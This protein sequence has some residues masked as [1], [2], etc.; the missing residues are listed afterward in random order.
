VFRQLPVAEQRLT[1]RALAA[2]AA[3]SLTLRL[4][5]FN[6]TYRLLAGR[7]LGPRSQSRTIDADL[8]ARAVDRAA[9]RWPAEATCLTRSLVLWWFLRRRGWP[10][11]VWV[12]VRR[13]ST[14]MEA[15]AWVELA[16]RVINDRPDVRE[17][18]AVFEQPL[19]ATP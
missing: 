4:F 9:R 10:A 13:G 11:D 15:H 17:H 16:G 7:A 6:R 2:I 3:T 8:V 18:Y 12:G 19:A 14:D 5:G 1:L